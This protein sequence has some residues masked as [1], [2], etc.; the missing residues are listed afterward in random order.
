MMLPGD[1]HRLVETIYHVKYPV[2]QVSKRTNSP[3][4]NYALESF[5]SSTGAAAYQ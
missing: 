3:E 2:E 1:K 4:G 5:L